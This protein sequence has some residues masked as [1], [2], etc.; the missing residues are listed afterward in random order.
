MHRRHI[1][2]RHRTRHSGL[3]LLQ[4]HHMMISEGSSWNPSTRS[5][6]TARKGTKTTLDLMHHVILLQRWSCHGSCGEDGGNGQ[7]SE[8]ETHCG[9]KVVELDI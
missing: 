5:G 1:Y 2:Q 3:W 6:V 8:G 7:K 4:T 9:G